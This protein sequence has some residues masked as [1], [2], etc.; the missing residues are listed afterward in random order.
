MFG[1]R[2]LVTGIMDDMAIMREWIHTP[3][4][5]RG[6][7]DVFLNGQLMQ[8]VVYADVRRG[9]IRVVDDPIKLCRYRKRVIS[10]TLRG[11]VSVTPSAPLGI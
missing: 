6:R 10:R 1:L 5:G 9:L 4:D 7:R 2:K 11:V 3:N 8:R